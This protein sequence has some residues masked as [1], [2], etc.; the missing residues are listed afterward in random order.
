MKKNSYPAIALIL[1]IVF[2]GSW[3][4]FM[5]K[6]S[7]NNNERDKKNQNTEVSFSVEDPFQYAVIPG[8]LDEATRARFG[9][10][11]SL[12][13]KA[14]EED[15]PGEWETWVAIGNMYSMFGDYERAIL[16]FKKSHEVH[17][18][19]LGQRNIAETYRLNLQDYE[20]AAIYYPR[21]LGEAPGDAG[22]YITFARMLQKQL[23]NPSEAEEVLSNGLRRIPKHPDILIALINLYKD[24]GNEA[25]YKE[26]VRIL[27]ETYPNEKQYQEAWGSVLK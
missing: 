1:I 21:A 11:L 15:G 17:P 8:A 2:L 14:F 22:L 9:E 19:I 6:P 25:P 27:L 12:T 26:A 18:N 16:S 10:T 20:Q 13:K 4:W 5:Y 24:T 23:N 7:F 3:Y